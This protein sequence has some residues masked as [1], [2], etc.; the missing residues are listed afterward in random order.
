MQAILVIMVKQYYAKLRNEGVITMRPRFDRCTL[1]LLLLLLLQACGGGGGSTSNGPARNVYG[2][3]ATGQAI[4][5]T[6][7]LRD[8]TGN[9]LRAAI[10]QPSGEFNIDVTGFTPPYFLKAADNTGTTTLYSVAT[11]DGNFNINPL[12]NLAVVAAAMTIDPLAKTPDAAFN[13]PAKFANLTPVLLQTS[14][15]KVM[16]QM[17]PEFRS[18]LADSRAI[19][20]SPLTDAFQVGNGLDKVLDNFVI[21]LAD[22]VIQEHQVVSNT[23]RVVGLVDIFGISPI[24]IPV[25][26]VVAVG[27]QPANLPP[28]ITQNAQQAVPPVSLSMI[29]GTYA[30]ASGSNSVFIGHIEA[31]GKI[32]GSGPGIAYSGLIQLE[33]PNTNSYRTTLVYQQNG[34]YGFVTGL[35]TFYD[36]AP[37]SASLPMPTALAPADYTGDIANLSYSQSTSGSQG[38]LVMQLSSPSE[39]ITLGAVRISSQ[40]QTI[41]VHPT[42]DTLMIQAVDSP[43]FTVTSAGDIQYSG[44][45]ATTSISGSIITSGVFNV[46]TN[47]GDIVLDGL[48]TITITLPQTQPALSGVGSVTCGSPALST[49][50]PAGTLII[51][52][53]PVCKTYDGSLYSG[54]NGVTY[55][56]FLNGDTPAVLGGTLTYGG[57]WHSS[58]NAGTYTII[59]G[60]LTSSSY[61]IIYVDST[62]TISRLNIPLT[63][64]K[65]RIYGG[66][67]VGGVAGDGYVSGA[68]LTSGT[69]TITNTSAGTI[70]STSLGTL[71]IS[72]SIAGNYSVSGGTI[73]AT[74]TP[75]IT[76]ATISVAPDGTISVVP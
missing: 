44:S 55:S 19:N 21:T 38:M 14:M 28:D 45:A 12:T 42:P 71:T 31:N 8:A 75:T 30:S 60:G 62:L 40:L 72:G 69:G 1:A 29:A 49:T 32:W 70:T 9:T 51:A 66:T 48:G 22:G 10:S 59:P 50:P 2:V 35:A 64:I 24:P 43:V 18:A 76:S 58:K 67:T 52:A 20:V 6:V 56:G 57:T 17:S 73:T 4:N 36:A 41:A 25:T 11:A 74:G 39:Q 54:G 33:D 65:I 23:T 16:A 63:V 47:P 61:N 15:D 27:I 5:G 26:N 13:D 46:L 34:Y 37:A 53:I 68:T 3:A 7:T